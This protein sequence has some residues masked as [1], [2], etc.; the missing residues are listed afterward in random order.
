MRPSCFQFWKYNYLSQTTP[1]VVTWQTAHNPI[2]PKGNKG[3]GSSALK[4]LL[5]SLLI[6]WLHP[7]AGIF[8]GLFFTPFHN[9]SWSYNLYHLDSTVLFLP[10]S[11]ICSYRHLYFACP[12]KHRYTY[13]TR[14]FRCSAPLHR[15]VFDNRCL[16]QVEFSLV[17]AAEHLTTEEGGFLKRPTCF[18]PLLDILIAT[19]Q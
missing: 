10:I 5:R 1:V 18:L 17:N 16:L 4:C 8:Q 15:G 9:A 19:P 3:E 12:L 6:W 11:G 13:G 7:S 2:R 14:L